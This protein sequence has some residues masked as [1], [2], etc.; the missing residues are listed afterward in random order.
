MDG[1]YL[2]WQ[3]QPSILNCIHMT[4]PGKEEKIIIQTTWTESCDIRV[5]IL[6]LGSKGAQ[7]KNLKVVMSSE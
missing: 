3:H 7:Q 6:A 4:C 1:F 5:S 2:G